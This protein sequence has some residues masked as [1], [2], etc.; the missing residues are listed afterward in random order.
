MNYYRRFPGDYGAATAHL[1]L[2]EHGAYTLLLDLY[3]TTEQPFPVDLD[4]CR[5]CRASTAAERRAVLKVADEFFPIDG[6]VRRNARADKELALAQ[7]KIAAARE[8]GKLGGRPP[9]ENPPDNPAKT[10]R[11]SPEEPVKNHP[12][13]TNPQ[14]LAAIPEPRDARAGNGRGKPGPI[15]LP[16]AWW[17]SD[18]VILDVCAKLNYPTLG[19]TQD[20]LKAR[21]NAA[22]EAGLAA[23]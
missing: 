17:A 18:K 6:D 19:K 12:P 5:I 15:K 2:A 9:K 3:Y 10:D 23:Q 11:D 4:L 7:P 22:I 8:N 14:P 21:I 13:E 16:R 1:S 20:Q